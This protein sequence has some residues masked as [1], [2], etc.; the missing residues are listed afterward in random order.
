MLWFSKS[1]PKVR[2]Y[3][4]T[5]VG[6]VFFSQIIAFFEGS[7]L[8]LLMMG[9]INIKLVSEGKAVDNISNSTAVWTLIACAVYLA[10]LSAFL[11]YSRNS[12]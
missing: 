11:I 8:L 9:T 4:M 12:L 3:A 10:S 7:F 5:K 2:T 6:E 1:C